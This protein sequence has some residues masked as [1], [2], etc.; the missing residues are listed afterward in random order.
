M[1]A[2]LTSTIDNLLVNGKVL[3]TEEDIYNKHWF[4]VT[5]DRVA[6]TSY[7]SPHNGVFV[8]IQLKLLSTSNL[9]AEL[10]IDGEV[11][12]AVRLDGDAENIALLSVFIPPNS[13]YELVDLGGVNIY[14]W[15]E[16]RTK[17]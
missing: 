14:K 7:H 16:Y 12:S 6:G 17:P 3:L 5:T 1:P 4:D 11:I 8:L 10:K 2:T 9:Y 15:S 13:S